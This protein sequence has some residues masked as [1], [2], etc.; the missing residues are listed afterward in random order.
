LLIATD[1]TLT[2]IPSPAWCPPAALAPLPHESTYRTHSRRILAAALAQLGRLD[3]AR[4]EAKLFLVTNP[5]FTISHWAYYK[6]F[7]DEA[8]RAHFAEG[9]R[10]A[11]LPE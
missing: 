11:G 5:H 2:L 7:G 3:K 6:G 9:Y 1:A 4:R 8:V 10:K